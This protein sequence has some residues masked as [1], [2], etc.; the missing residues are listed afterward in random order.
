MSGPIRTG[1]GDYKGVLPP[2]GGGDGFSLGTTQFESELMEQGG[3]ETGVDH[4]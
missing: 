1:G 4:E 3:G 2:R